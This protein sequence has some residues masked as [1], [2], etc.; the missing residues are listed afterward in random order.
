MYQSLF[1]VAGRRDCS[2]RF[3][4]GS[5][6]TSHGSFVAAL[7]WLHLSVPEPLTALQDE[8]CLCKRVCDI[9][10]GWVSSPTR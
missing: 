5:P 2:G 1:R 7:E 3:D 10:G 8:S 4:V 6:H 9:A